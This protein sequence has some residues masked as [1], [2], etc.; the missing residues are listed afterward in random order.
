MESWYIIWHLESLVGIWGSCILTSITVAEVK[1]NVGNVSS[2]IGN[3]W[4]WQRE[5][6]ERLNR[7]K[8][9]GK[10]VCLKWSWLMDE[11]R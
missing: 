1:R 10:W 11:A 7:N 8:G 2:E 9:A 5:E 4:W 3:E 6:G